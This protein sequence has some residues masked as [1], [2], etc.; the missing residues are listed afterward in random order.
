MTEAADKKESLLSNT[1]ALALPE[2][3]AFSLE[4]QSGRPQR[5]VYYFNADKHLFHD[6]QVM[7]VLTTV[8]TAWFSNS[9]APSALIGLRG[10]QAFRGISQVEIP[11]ALYGFPSYLI[12]DEF[13][14]TESTLRDLFDVIS[15][16]IGVIIN[17]RLQPFMD[18]LLS[19]IWGR[20]GAGMTI[21]EAVKGLDLAIPA[22][23]RRADQGLY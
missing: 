2:A 20:L 1:P 6:S 10:S 18:P 14:P 5:R 21:E 9:P 22:Q 3:A 13:V 12:I 15:K 7:R 8:R 23:A 11:L 17:Q 19:T 4:L 16:D